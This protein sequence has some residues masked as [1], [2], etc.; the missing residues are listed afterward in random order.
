M[1]PFDSRVPY[2][3]ETRKKYIDIPFPEGEYAERIDKIRGLMQEREL[4]ALLVY[5]YPAG[6]EGAGH[7][8]YLTSFMPL[9]GDAAL[10][11][12]MD[13]E[14]TLIFDRVFHSE[15][16]HSMNWTTWVRDV[17][18]STRENVPANIKAWLEERGLDKGK[19]G[20]VG[21]R[22]LPWDLWNQTRE[23][24]PEATW[25]PVTR[26]FNDIQKIKSPSEMDLMRKVC[27]MTDEGM[28]AG[29]EAVSSGV[30]EGEIVGEISREFARQGA[31]GVS[32]SPCIAS[33]PRGGLKHSYPTDRK[34]RKGDI[35]YIDVGAK[36]Y[37]YNTDM[38][39]VV[40]VGAPTPKQK[41]LLDADREAYYTLLDEMRP[42]V[43][44]TEIHGMARE[45][46]KRSGIYE[47]YG[48][49]AYVRFAGSHA[50]ATGYAEWSLEDGRTVLTSNLSPLAFEPMIVILDLG[51]IVIESMV[52]IT[53]KGAEVLTPLEVDW[54]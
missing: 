8:T 16:T 47:R 5:S 41:Y 1:I 48:E 45:M 10:L 13:G 27:K 22:M 40:V 17:H 50:L 37:G 26:A 19:I 12:P 44:V 14:P 2:D 54:M 29:L 31:H 36:Y 15:P 23:S 3:F 32:F 53:G 52:A 4:G 20:L 33:G 9:G 39:R 35:V 34:I 28:R 24:L 49:G 46:E 7:L 18:P 25:K 43:P 6:S 11:L 51:T 30:S 42:G 38:S 21:E